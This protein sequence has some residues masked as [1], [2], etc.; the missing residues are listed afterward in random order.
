MTDNEQPAAKGGAAMTSRRGLKDNWPPTINPQAPK[1]R[2][3]I[4][5]QEHGE[6]APAHGAAAGHEF[7]GPAR[8]INTPPRGRT[9]DLP[10]RGRSEI[11]EDH[12]TLGGP[13]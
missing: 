13:K 8:G 7:D 3:G 1:S 6:F 12:P 10:K 9:R 2:A 5:A 4:D 11:T